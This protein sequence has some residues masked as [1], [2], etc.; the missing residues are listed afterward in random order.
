MNTRLAAVEQQKLQQHLDSIR[1]L[2][3]QFAEPT[4]DDG[5]H[6]HG[7]GQAER[8]DVP[9]AQALQRRRA[10]L[11]RDHELVHRPAHAGVR[12]RHHALRDVFMA[13]LSYTAIRSG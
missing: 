7:P 5:H 10:L 1:D 9:V 3:K 13:D 6:L 8:D 11:R 4:T 2:E 12:V